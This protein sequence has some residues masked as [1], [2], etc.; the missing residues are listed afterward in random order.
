MAGRFRLI[1]ARIVAPFEHRAIRI[2]KN[3]SME[4]SRTLTHILCRTGAMLLLVCAGL[5]SAVAANAA[6]DAAEREVLAAVLRQLDLLDRLAEQTAAASPQERSR[7]HF[8]HARL[9]EDVKRVRT[10]VQDYLIPQRAQP[11]DPVPLTGDYA[12]SRTAG[13]K[14]APSP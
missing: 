8:D 10:G 4:T 12:R 1:A 13:D 14:E 5:S 3:G 9:R 2:P 11:R 6:D 7:Y